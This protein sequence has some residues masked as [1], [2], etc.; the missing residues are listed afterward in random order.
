M[1]QLTG[2]ERK[3]IRPGF[4]STPTH[5]IIYFIMANESL[6]LGDPFLTIGGEALSTH[7]WSN[8]CDPAL[9]TVIAR[10]QFQYLLIYQVV[11]AATPN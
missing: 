4:D 10:A 8:V 11:S 9:I 3:C 5:T 6:Y 7:M 1:G 2:Q